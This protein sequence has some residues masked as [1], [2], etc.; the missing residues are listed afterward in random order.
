LVSIDLDEEVTFNDQPEV[1]ILD[2]EN[3]DPESIAR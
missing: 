2:W 1:E 3:E